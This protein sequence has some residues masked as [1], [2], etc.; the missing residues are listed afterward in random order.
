MLLVHC[1]AL[2]ELPC[3]R[4]WMACHLNL[5]RRASNRHQTGTWFGFGFT[6]PTCEC[7]FQANLVVYEQILRDMK[8]RGEF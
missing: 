3:L 4:P 7:L 1:E 2:F 6:I 5:V 8:V